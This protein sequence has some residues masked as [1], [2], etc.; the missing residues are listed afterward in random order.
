MPCATITINAPTTFRD[1]YTLLKGSQPGPPYSGLP[2]LPIT[3]YVVAPAQGII[4]LGV[5]QRIGYLSIQ[6]AIEN[7]AASIV[8]VGDENLQPGTCQG[9]E[10]APGVIAERAME[11][12]TGL[13]EIYLAA[14][15]SGL[16]VNIEL[17]WE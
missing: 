2:T 11:N 12:V 3:G 14:S 13:G 17:H 7:A 6:S 1:L 5:G 16:K 15:A 8:Y 10:L 9:K 4:G